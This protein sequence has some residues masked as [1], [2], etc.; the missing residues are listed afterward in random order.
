MEVRLAE[1]YQSNGYYYEVTIDGEVE[2]SW[3]ETVNGNGSPQGWDAVFETAK[4]AGF[5][6]KFGP[7]FEDWKAEIPI[8]GYL[9]KD[10]PVIQIGE[11][12]FCNYEQGKVRSVRVD[13]MYDRVCFGNNNS[14]DFGDFTK[15]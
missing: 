6:E 8:I 7:D 5:G 2:Y 4:T 13:K 11:S 3:Y 12:F 10:F 15:A 9:N 1:I 14:E